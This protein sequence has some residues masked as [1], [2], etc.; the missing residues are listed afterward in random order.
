MNFREI[1]GHNKQIGHLQNSLIKGKNVHAYVFNGPSGI[2]KRFVAKAF[3][4]TILCENSNTDSCG[5]C[6]SCIKLKTDNHPDIMIIQSE[7]GSVKNQQVEEFQSFV[8][9]KPYVSNHKIILIEDADNMTVSAQNRI[10]KVLEEPPSYVVVILITSNIN[11]LVPTIRSRCLCINFHSVPSDLI[12]K[13]LVEKFNIEESKAKVVANFSNGSFEIALRMLESE[14]FEED[15]TFIQDLFDAINKKKKTKLFD[16]I[17]VLEK[18]KEK[19]LEL[20]DLLTYWYRDLV[21]LVEKA[22]VEMLINQDKIQIL[23]SYVDGLTLNELYNSIAEIEDAKRAV[24]E[25]VNL[26][27]NMESLIIAL[28]EVRNG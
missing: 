4:S 13:Y 18:N 6:G 8:N 7:S 16:F 24:R 27:A 11:R 1:I 14:A 10:L 22:D 26:S 23:K 5:N 20:L 28:Q 25:Q 2:G 3:M 12:S 21:F 17:S 15:R 19:T 9:I